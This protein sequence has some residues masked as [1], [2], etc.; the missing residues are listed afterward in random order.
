MNFDSD[1]NFL[2]EDDLNLKDMSFEEVVTAW[3][4]WFKTAQLTNAEDENIFSHSCF[5]S[6]VPGDS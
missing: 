2:S 6:T 3:N 4:E 1:I 5:G